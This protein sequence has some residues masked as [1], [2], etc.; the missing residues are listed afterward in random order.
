MTKTF[1]KHFSRQQM[2][3]GLR[4]F[5]F[6]DKALLSLELGDYSKK[7]EQDYEH[8]DKISIQADMWR[9]KYLASR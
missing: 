2:L 6:R 3:Q 5:Y 9:S 1:L 4:F 8:L 7:V